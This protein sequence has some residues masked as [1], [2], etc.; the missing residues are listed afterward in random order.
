M[1]IAQ[2]NNSINFP[3]MC[4]LRTNLL[5]IVL[6]CPQTQT[7]FTK[8]ILYFDQFTVPDMLPVLR[9]FRCEPGKDGE[10]PTAVLHAHTDSC[11]LQVRRQPVS[12]QSLLSHLSGMWDRRFYW[13]LFCWNMDD[14]LLEIDFVC[15]TSD[16]L[17]P[18]VSHKHLHVILN[19]G[20][21]NQI[22]KGKVYWFY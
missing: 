18:N 8:K 9:D 12:A 2:T 10:P 16:S 19:I 14:G 3:L 20:I 17:T 11:R 21:V 13:H 22:H 4:N 6:C 7:N 15:L 1:H 5:W